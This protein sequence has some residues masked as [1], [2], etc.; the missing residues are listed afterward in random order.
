MAAESNTAQDASK[1]DTK[2]EAKTKKAKHTFML[3]E[4]GT[5][6][7]IGK[8]AGS[9]W[10]YSALKAASRGHKKIWVRRTNTKEMREY[11]GDIVKLE[12]PKE[13][14]RGD[15]TITYTQ[16][17]TVKFVKKWTFQGTT[18]QDDAVPISKQVPQQE[19]AKA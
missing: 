19:E 2:P 14:K 13:V 3:H 4:V 7:C 15:R 12:T 17:P 16:R 9:D 8:M 6:A 10:R 18:A 5:Y 11:E 1:T